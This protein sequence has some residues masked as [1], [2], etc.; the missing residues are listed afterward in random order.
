[1][2]PKKQ[3]WS[4]HKTIN[5]SRC[6]TTGTKRDTGQVVDNSSCPM[7]PVAAVSIHMGNCDAFLVPL[8]GE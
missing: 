6:H 1:M 7:K 5:N 8:K 2:H 3:V 4:E